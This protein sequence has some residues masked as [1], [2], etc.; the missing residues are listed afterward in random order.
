MIPLSFFSPDYQTARRRFRSAAAE[1]NALQE[2]HGILI[3]GQNCDGGLSID[4]AF[5]GSECPDWTLVVTSGLHGV[6]GFFGSAIQL[7][8]L[9]QFGSGRLL[10]RNG[11]IV[12]GHSLNPYGFHF[13]R[14]TNEENIDLN[15]NF[16]LSHQAYAGLSAGYD[17]L[18]QFLNPPSPPSL[19]EPL[20]L[21]ALLLLMRAGVPTLKVGIVSGQY[22][23]PK[24]LFFGGRKTARSTCIVQTC[25]RRWISGAQRVAHIDFHTGLGA[26]GTYKLR[27]P[28]NAVDVEWY[29]NW[30]GA[31]SVEETASENGTAHRSTGRMGRW[32]NRHLG[33]VDYHYF[34]AEFGTYSPLHTL[35]VLRSENRA[36]FYAPPGSVAHNRAKASIKECFCPG[37]KKWR[38]SALRQG[39]EL[40]DKCVEA[41]GS[42]D[43]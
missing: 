17:R 1:A 42:T 32:L 23:F 22:D 29:R 4:I 40:V 14:R 34:N 13:L 9:T 2:H 38:I 24:G 35:G 8:L 27:L 10:P 21:K 18:N 7:A 15:R 41:L 36:H 25:Y 3:P 31:Q 20:W 5:I 26:F 11:R 19:L 16:L 39:L 43:G 37:S 33:D 28:V 12:L 6:E 30:F